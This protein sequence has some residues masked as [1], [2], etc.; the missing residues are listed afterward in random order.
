MH[1]SIKSRSTAILL[2]FF[3]G[4]LGVHK[5]YLRRPGQGIA[6]VLF[7]WTFI[8]AIIAFCEFIYYLTLSSRQFDWHYNRFMFDEN[9]NYKD[10]YKA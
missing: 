10:K 9:G 8:P 7:V 2:A 6:Y 1:R 3:L 4:G 5:F